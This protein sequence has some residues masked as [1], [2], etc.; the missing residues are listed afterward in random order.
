MAR[1][2]GIPRQVEGKVSVADRVQAGRARVWPF[3]TIAMA[4]IAA[5][6]VDAVM[7]LHR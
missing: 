7:Y 2:F 5:G 6:I 3:V 1:N 4:F